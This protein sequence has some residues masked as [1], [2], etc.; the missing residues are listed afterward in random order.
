MLVAVE[1]TFAGSKKTEL[2]QY[3]NV[4]FGRSRC[5]TDPKN[6]P[7]R[8]A[9]MTYD[10]DVPDD[11][12]ESFGELIGLGQVC[13]SIRNASVHRGKTSQSI[14]IPDDSQVAVIRNHPPCEDDNGATFFVNAGLGQQGCAWLAKRPE[15]QEILCTMDHKSGAYFACRKSCEM[16]S[17]GDEEGLRR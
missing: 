9:G 13:L 16:C 8:R 1:I 4:V 7:D 6:E 12:I 10:I 5:E 11:I 14:T 2:P 15:H 17:A 3:S